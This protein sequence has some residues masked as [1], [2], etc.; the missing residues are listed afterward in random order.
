MMYSR[1][2]NAENVGGMIPPDYSGVAYRSEAQKTTEEN[3]LH[4]E[5]DSMRR[6]RRALYKED[7]TAKEHPFGKRRTPPNIP[8]IS[9]K[10]DTAERNRYHVSPSL[11]F[12]DESSYYS[13]KD[14]YDAY[15]AE[16]NSKLDPEMQNQ[17]QPEEKESAKN[18]T[19]EKK[20]GIFPALSRLTKHSFTM[21]DILL[22][23]LILL[24]LN[25]DGDSDLLLI[26]GFLLLT[27]LS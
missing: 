10:D 18:Q 16:E 4:K 1:K 14:R 25:G 21:E 9:D 3:S 13:A 6:P 5:S 8:P 23:G 20:G 12:A 22:V 24:L 27:G 17:E 7:Y 19:N 15:P 11:D 2:F 26:L